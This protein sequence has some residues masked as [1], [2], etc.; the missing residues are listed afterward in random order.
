[1]SESVRSGGRRGLW[2]APGI[3]SIVL[4]CLLCTT[5][6]SDL[7][8]KRKP[9]KRKWNVNV[10]RPAP[11]ESPQRRRWKCSKKCRKRVA[12]EVTPES[13]PHVQVFADP[14]APSV[15]ETILVTVRLMEGQGEARH[16][17]FHVGADP[18]LLRFVGYRPT[19]RGVLM[20][21]ERT[22]GSGEL[23]V[24]R[25]SLSEGFAA[26]EALV[27]L[28]FESLAPGSGSVAINDVRLLDPS[29]RDLGV[30]YEAGD[31]EIR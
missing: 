12:K 2:R 8:A 9:K 20:V 30:T 22:E 28:E 6:S 7:L 21:Q 24:Y 27:E 18:T 5:G 13:L 17:A 26:V 1:M 16:A 15:G 3:V 14:V 23:I 10:E 31:F 4:A 25:S 29:A 11:P 19:G